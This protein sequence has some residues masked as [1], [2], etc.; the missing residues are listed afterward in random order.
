[1]NIKFTKFERGA[2]FFILACFLSSVFFF[3]G[4]AV[5]KGWFSSAETF[6]VFLNSAEGIQS[7]TLVQM[8]GLNVGKV[9]KTELISQGKIKVD[10]YVFS[11]YV[12]KLNSATRMTVFRPFIIGEKVLDIQLMDEAGDEKSESAESHLAVLAPGSEIP[13]ITTVDLMDILSGKKMGG[14][15]ASFDHLANSISILGEAFADGKRAKEFVQ[16]MDRIQPLVKNLNTM[17]VE[18]TKVTSVALKE[19]RLEQIA[20]NIN[21]LTTEFKKLTPAITTIAPDL[22]RTTLRAVEA[23]DEAVVLLKAMQKSFLLRG[24]VK[25]VEAEESELQRLPANK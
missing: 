2:G 21:V 3:A 7:G 24:K 17:S 11:E 23:L 1:M 8:S 4:V 9:K 5:K 25:E 14:F 16:L 22:P 20:D 12:P 10:F 18:M 13:V 15:L 19:Q 6:H